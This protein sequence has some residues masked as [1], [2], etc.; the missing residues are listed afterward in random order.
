M[1]QISNFTLE[2]LHLL[3][4]KVAYLKCKTIFFK[5]QG[6]TQ[7]SGKKEN[8]IPNKMKL[9]KKKTELSQLQKLLFYIHAELKC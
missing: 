8:L 9:L 3:C 1:M 7:L 5:S 6:K 4:A 2:S